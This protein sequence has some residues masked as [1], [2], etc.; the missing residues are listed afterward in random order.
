MF[1]PSHKKS[2]FTLIELLVALSIGIMII[3]VASLVFTKGVRH[4]RAI[5]GETKLVEAAAHLTN[6][7]TYE[8]RPAIA[9]N[10]S[11]GSIT[12]TKSDFT[13]TTIGLDNN[14]VKIDGQVILQPNVLANDLTFTIIDTKTVQVHYE[15]A[16][17]Q[18][19]GIHPDF[20]VL[21]YAATTTI[22]LR[23]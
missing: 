16:L 9:A 10:A 14:T 3:L 7:L 18:A 19:A 1:Y 6:V 13:E 22:S 15:L 4:T 5:N 2:G 20:N 12:L 8:I 17:A 11:G 23:N 21:P